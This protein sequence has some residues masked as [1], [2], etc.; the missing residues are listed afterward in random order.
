L[1][2]TEISSAAIERAHT[3]ADD[4]LVASLPA[5]MP[6]RHGGSLYRARLMGL[7][8]ERTAAPCVPGILLSL[9][10]MAALP[11]LLLTNIPPA[12]LMIAFGAI[13]GLSSGPIF[14]LA[15][16]G[17]QPE[18]RAL[19]MRIL[20]TIFYAAMAAA[21]PLAGFARDITGSPATPFHVAA[22]SLTATLLDHLVGAG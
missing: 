7:S 11:M 17:L 10:C 22:A 13:V 21:P 16:E 6:V 18:E 8:R 3:D 4:L 15:S 5:I 19:A 1:A 9:A 12:A 20:F 2:L 14:A